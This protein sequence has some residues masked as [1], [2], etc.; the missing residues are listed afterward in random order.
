MD[1]DDAVSGAES[2]SN[3]EMEPEDSWTFNFRKQ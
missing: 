2:V 3:K 1:Y